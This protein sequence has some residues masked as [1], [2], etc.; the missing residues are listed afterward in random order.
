MQ[1]YCAR[2]VLAISKDITS[3]RR[4]S[5]APGLARRRWRAFET[6][7]YAALDCTAWSARTCAIT[8]ETRRAVGM[9]RNSFR[10][11]RVRVGPEHTGNDK[12]RLRKFLAQHRHE[13][14][15]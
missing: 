7:R 8:S 6:G 9:C 3:A 4:P 1:P 10:A 11:V 13:R 12:L 15:A 2:R 14:D 5:S